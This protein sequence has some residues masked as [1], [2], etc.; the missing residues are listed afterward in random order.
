MVSRQLSRVVRHLR[1]IVRPAETRALCDAQ[2]LEH[3]ARRRD[4]AAFEVLLSRHGPMVRG[5]C[6]QLLRDAHDAE[7]AF[8]ATFLILVQKAGSLREGDLLGHW[9]YG[10]A[11]RVAARVRAGRNRRRAVER[12]DADAVGSAAESP[13][14]EL[15]WLLHEE[16]SRLPEKYRIPVV[17]CYL[18]GNTNEEAARRL[19][20]PV[21]TVKGRLTRAR[22][23][24]R[25]RLNRQGVTLS[26]GALA[27]ALSPSAA[28]A[29]PPP[30]IVSTVKAA[31]ALAT[32]GAAAPGGVPASVLALVHG[33]LRAMAL[34]RVK[35]AAAVLLTLA[36]LLPATGLLAYRALMAQAVVA[37]PHAGSAKSPIPSRANGVAAGEEAVDLK[38]RLNAGQP[39]YQTVTTDVAQAMKL[40][41]QDVAQNHAQTFWLR[42]TPQGEQ[43]GTYRVKQRVIGLKV[44]VNL[45]GNQMNYD[46]RAKDQ[47]G[48]P[49]AELGK[50]VRDAEFT[51]HLDSE[52]RSAR[53]LAVVKVEGQEELLKRLAAGKPQI[54]PLLQNIFSD[55]ALKQ[56]A[57]PYP[58]GVLC[59]R[60]VRKGASWTGSGKQD[61][62]PLGQYLTTYQYNYEGR[63]GAL[64]R[65]AVKTTLKYS[66]PPAGGRQNLPFGI[67]K[68]DFTRADGR[69][70]V[71]FD[72]VRGRIARAKLETRLEGP[73]TI[74]IGGTD[75][76]VEV[77]QT[78]TMTV[79]T[80]DANPL[81]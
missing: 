28:A 8:Q 75:T 81:R 62:G 23:L 54:A 7:D 41:Q 78:Q 24:L 42:W 55:E 4:E 40:R 31:L 14:P 79:T 69:G 29:L 64:D 21:G 66:P 56:L 17:L 73:L 11:Y 13:E 53:Y 19:H 47:A 61:L 18:E 67:V 1:R 9:L 77:A 26:S 52:P 25:R 27:A 80:T 36:V 60:P 22:T 70:V 68:A 72:R 46:S 30:L 10:V 49:L 74:R 76:V 51:A 6:R 44:D 65:I 5:L 37:T 50:A 71:L 12:L 2:L 58:D 34:A 32:G 39:F 57:N 3:F 45:A 35:V 16:L 43:D 48:N 20:W 33:S 59:G 15:R 38:V 63:E